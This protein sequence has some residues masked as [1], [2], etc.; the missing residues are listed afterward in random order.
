MPLYLARRASIIALLL[1]ALLATMSPNMA[2]LGPSP[3]DAQTPG[4]SVPFP[5]NPHWQRNAGSEVVVQYRIDGS[6]K[7]LRPLVEDAV[8]MWNNDNPGSPYM[9][10]QLL[11]PG[12]DC[13]SNH[14][15]T[16]AE[17]NGIGCGAGHT[18]LQWSSNVP[19]HLHMLPALLTVNLQDCAGQ[20][21]LWAK[22]V[23]C[24]EVGHTQGVAHDPT[25]TRPCSPGDGHPAG[26][27][28]PVRNILGAT[29][30]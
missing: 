13:T 5:G 28:I 9:H 8:Y 17:N 11:P 21:L 27:D 23:M 19:G 30:G 1:S 20:T 25:N 18:F 3:A 24:H 22:Y 2:L 26:Q 6:A 4:N 10:L 29:P 16:V 7:A 12:A 15:V 14:C